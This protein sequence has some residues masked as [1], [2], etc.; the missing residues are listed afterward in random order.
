ML[1]RRKAMMGWLIYTAA[2]PIAKRA[3]RKKARGAVPGTREGSRGPNKAAIV[4]GLGALA[5]GLMFW[6]SRGDGDG[7]AGP[8]ES[9]DS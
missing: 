7:D 5:A 4:A 2:K 8:G 9:S 1:N 6:R 3:L